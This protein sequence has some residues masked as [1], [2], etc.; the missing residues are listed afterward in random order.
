MIAIAV[1]IIFPLVNQTNGEIVS[2]GERRKYLLYVPA[3]YDPATPSPLII[4]MHGFAE[5]PAH[6]MEIS[7][8][9]EL[10]DEHG[11]IVVYPAGTGFPLRWR[12]SAFRLDDEV[13]LTDVKFIADLIDELMQTYNIDET[14]IYANGLSNGGGMAYLLACKLSDRIAAIGGVAGAY[15]FPWDDCHPTR[16]VPLIA[17]HGSNDRIVPYGG[18]ESRPFE[19]SLPIIPDWVMAWGD[20]NGCD[21]QG[22][23][24]P[25]T[26][27]VSGIQYT[28]CDQDADVILYTIAGGGHTWPGGKPIVES[29][30]GHTTQEI[31]ATRVMW[32]FFQDFTLEH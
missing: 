14:R 20:R 11:L 21:E 23:Q 25:A 15:M 27:G 12:A 18:G 9:N 16:P 10:A 26:G 22:V 3:S 17:F 28:N 24:I 6:I 8:W 7:H 32:E 13:P 2:S 31:D 19:Y 30:V 4:S 29:I 5:W 1:A